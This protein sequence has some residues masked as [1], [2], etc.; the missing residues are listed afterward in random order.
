VIASGDGHVINIS[1]LNG[2]MAQGGMSH[3]CTSKFGVR[4]FT[5][6]L[7]VE[8]LAAGHPVGVTAVH[9]GGIRTSIADNALEAARALGLPVT[10]A[11]EARRRR[12]NEKLLR[13]PPEAAAETIIKGVEAGR[14]R[15]LVG[16]DA[17]VVDLLVRALPGLYPKGLV[18]LERRF[19]S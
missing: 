8:M 19:M 9:P 15:V 7:R 12:Y 2:Y 1:S 18:A 3:Y 16:G 10:E 5:E 13:M 6:S 14:G 4:G 17:K 11:E